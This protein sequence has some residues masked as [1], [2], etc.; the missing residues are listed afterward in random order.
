MIIIH[1]EKEI[2]RKPVGTLKPS[3]CFYLED[4]NDRLYMYIE[5][6]ISGNGIDTVFYN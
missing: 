4:T 1:E 6:R 3:D 5:H 2:D